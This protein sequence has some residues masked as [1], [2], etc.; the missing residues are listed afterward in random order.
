MTVTLNYFWSRPVENEGRSF[1]EQF[2]GAL[3]GNNLSQKAQKYNLAD[4]HS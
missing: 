1:Q 4:S 2:I 3:C